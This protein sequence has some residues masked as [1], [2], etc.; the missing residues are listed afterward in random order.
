MSKKTLKKAIEDDDLESFIEEHKDDPPGDEDKLEKVIRRSDR[1][2]ASSA[3][4]TSSKA[5]S[6]D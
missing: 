2:T 4:K 5:S 3:P 1:G 6:D